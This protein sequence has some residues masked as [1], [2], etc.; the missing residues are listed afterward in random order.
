L[1]GVPGYR[2]IAVEGRGGIGIVYRPRHLGRNRTVALKMLLS[3]A[4]AGRVERGRFLREARAVAGLRHAD[5]AQVFDVGEFE[6]R[7][8]FTMEFVDG[9]TLAVFLGGKPQPSAAA[10][11]MLVTLA[12]AIA[13]AHGCGIIHRDLKPANVL[14]AGD[15]T[16]KVSDFG[17][18][19]LR[20]GRRR[21]GGGRLADSKI[22][23]PRRTGRRALRLD[24]DSGC[25]RREARLA[26]RRASLREY[27][28]GRR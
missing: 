19:R 20:H 25:S 1:P 11:A 4:F 7:P 23:H 22:Q 3:R 12:D 10:A 13:Y 9:C 2:L 28:P 5:I 21:P 24:A 17:L 6:R 8:F 15:G 16:L 14:P 18:A 27:A 26:V